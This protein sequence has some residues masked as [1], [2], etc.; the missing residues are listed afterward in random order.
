MSDFADHLL[1]HVRAL[2]KQHPPFADMKRSDIDN[3][4][5]ADLGSKIRRDLADWIAETEYEVRAEIEADREYEAMMAMAAKKAK[6]AKPAQ[7]QEGHHEN[8]HR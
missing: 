1:D 5:L 2:L 7:K 3:G 6:R 4:V 8:H